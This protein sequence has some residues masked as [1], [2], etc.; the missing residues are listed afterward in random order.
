MKI[1]NGF[2]SNSS[3]SSFM[4]PTSFLTDEQKEVLLSMDDSKE[5]KRKMSEWAGWESKCNSDNSFPINEEYHQILNKM[6]EEK[7]FIDSPWE[8]GIKKVG[9]KEYLCG[10]TLM[11]NGSINAFMEKIGIDITALEI[12]ND[13]HGSVHMATNPKAMEFFADVIEEFKKTYEESSDEEKEF[14]LKNLIP[15]KNPYKMK[16]DEFKKFQDGTLYIDFEDGPMYFK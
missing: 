6:I 5:V 14:F 8:T 11:W 4:I 3:S 16:D 13:G 10:S 1:R 9:S 2:V 15:E 12:T 7:E